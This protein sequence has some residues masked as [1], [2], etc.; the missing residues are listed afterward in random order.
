MDRDVAHEERKGALFAAGPRARQR[1]YEAEVAEA[2]R[3]GHYARM[4]WAELARDYN[5]TIANVLMLW[6]QVDSHFTDESDRSIPQ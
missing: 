3:H 1:K 6:H 4:L 5:A 2:I